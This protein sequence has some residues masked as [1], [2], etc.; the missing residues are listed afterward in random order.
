MKKH[1]LNILFVTALTVLSLVL[2]AAGKFVSEDNKKIDPNS[3]VR[4]EKV[5]DGDTLRVKIG[6]YSE[7]IRLIGIDAPEIGQRPW[8]NRAKKHLESL[9]AASAWKVVIE[10]DVEKNDQYGRVLAYLKTGD[11]KMLNAEMLRHGYAVLFTFPPNV[12]HVDELI[13]AQKQAREKMLGIWGGN[14]LKQMPSEYR[15]EHPRTF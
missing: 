10:Y 8:G 9:I 15:K 6:K 5:L 11:G 12:K 13:A 4:V 7:E 3:T 1:Q 14:G 2:G